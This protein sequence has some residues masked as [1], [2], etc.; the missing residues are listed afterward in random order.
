MTL[1]RPLCAAAAF[2][3]ACVTGCASPGAPPGGPP[4]RTAPVIV[5]VT[6]DSGAT[7][8]KGKN[9]TVEFN[10]VV[11]ERPRGGAD[12]AAILVLSP[13]DG[14]AR[15]DW[16]RDAVTVRPRKGFRAN[17]AYSLTIMPGLSDLSGNAT[18]TARTLVFST[19]PSIPH[20]RIQGAVFDWT[21]IRPAVGA[22]IDAR[23][24][25]DTTFRWIA[26]TDSTGRYTLPF[27]PTGAYV[28]RAHLDA[29]SNGRIEPR[30]LWD[31]LT[32]TLA[33]SLRVD[34]Y[35][36][37]HDTLGARVVGVD[38][39]DSVTLRLTFDRPLALDGAPQPEQVEVR[40]ADSSRVRVRSV[41]RA[42]QFDSLNRVR[43][44]A[45]RDSAQ[46]A[47]TS[48]AGKRARARADSLR[49][50]SERDSI[51]RSRVE[52][53]RATRDTVT[54]VRP[55]VP[56][57]EAISAEFVVV[58]EEPIP[59][60]NYRV[61]TRQVMSVSRIL[62]TS[63]RTFSRA[64]PVE[65]K[66]D[67]AAAPKGA[68]P[69]PSAG[70]GKPAATPSGKP[71]V[72]PSVKSANPAPANPAPANPAPANPAPAPKVPPGRSSSQ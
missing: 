5:K 59:P 72:P 53:R 22:L 55:P 7:G 23:I 57:R 1:P 62:R 44:A 26:R 39:K 31:T 35:A 49:V 4:D 21:T 28:L 6:P 69:P 46:R 38:V 70:P 16:H 60:G 25:A 61:T 48:V 40:R 64:K 27:L 24:G 47:D 63:E 32:V 68:A 33:D 65:K 42:A 45:T 58:L 18:K 50:L 15:V 36:F 51:E 9:V 43:E 19:G 17:T 29:N 54:K 8:V 20:G 71:V 13:S 14:P 30:E 11:S 37:T 52:A 12:L 3:V 2:A 41:G 67:D 10:E 56:T 66:K 34:L